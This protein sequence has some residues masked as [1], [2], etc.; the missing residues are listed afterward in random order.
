[1]QAAEARHKLVLAM[2]DAWRDGGGHGAGQVMMWC[3]A[4]AMSHGCHDMT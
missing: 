3:H 4:P 2:D 1:V